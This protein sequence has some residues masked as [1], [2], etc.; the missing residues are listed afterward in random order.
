M[1]RAT[2]A[3]PNAG[4]NHAEDSR[5]SWKCRFSISHCDWQSNFRTMRYVAHR[6]SFFFFKSLLEYFIAHSLCTFTLTWTKIAWAVLWLAP[7][8]CHCAN[9]IKIW[10]LICWKISFSI[11]NNRSNG[12]ISFTASKMPLCLASWP[13][14]SLAQALQQPHAEQPDSPDPQPQILVQSKQTKQIFISLFFF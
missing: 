12:I 14:S 7:C 6:E 8:I 5:T 1:L 13:S 2:V 4:V 3:L 9:T 10:A 11:P